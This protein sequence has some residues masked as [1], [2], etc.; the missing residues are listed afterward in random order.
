MS[1]PE[2]SKK[3]DLLRTHPFRFFQTRHFVQNQNPKFP[4]RPPETLVDLLVALDHE[5][6]RLISS[7]YSLI[8]SA[9][10]SSATGPRD[11][12]EQ[13][14]GITLPDDYW[15]QVLRLVHSSSICA[16][17]GL[18]QCKVVHKVHYT[19]LRLSRIY[20]NVT[21]SCNRC[22]Q[23]PANHSHM[24]CLCPR[25]TTFWSDVFKT[26]STAYNTT[27]LSDPL[28]VLFGAPLQP[29]TSK[30]IQTV[31]A[32][33]T[34]LARRLILLN[35]KHAQPPS[36]SRWVKEILLSIRLEKLRFSLNCSLSSF[37][38]TWRPFLNH[39]ESL[40]SLPDCDD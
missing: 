13:E 38:K 10:D 3:F 5:Q 2:L 34:L 20:P 28:L 14:L 21:D 39:I 12:W 18:L 26:L 9:T 11:S 4:S 19:N 22:K 35:W 32:F 31:L 6:K 27:I 36:H 7:I 33:A 16:R 23:S 29:V 1:F 8:S 40:T 15:Q 30:V 37:E 25:L 17:H 24:F